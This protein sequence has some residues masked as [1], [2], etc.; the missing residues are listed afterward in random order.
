MNDSKALPPLAWNTKTHLVKAI[1][2]IAKCD[3]SHPYPPQNEDAHTLPPSNNA[4]ER[5]PP[6]GCAPTYCTYGSSANAP[7]PN[8]IEGDAALRVA[9]VGCASIAGKQHPPRFRYFHSLLHSGY[10]DSRKSAR[11]WALG[12]GNRSGDQAVAWW[13]PGVVR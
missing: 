10:A 5:P 13:Q 11:V 1:D 9:G 3:G 6:P 12:I 2:M 7:T 8:R 4:G